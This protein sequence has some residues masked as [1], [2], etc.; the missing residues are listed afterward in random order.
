MY[1]FI[2]SWQ[3]NEISV[4]V[5]PILQMDKLRLEQSNTG[6]RGFEPDSDPDPFVFLPHH[7]ATW[8]LQ[9]TAYKEQWNK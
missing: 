1:H 5:T 6:R 7:P 4:R 3:P 2:E 8:F 9:R